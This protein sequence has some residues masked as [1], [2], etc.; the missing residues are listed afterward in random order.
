MKFE[1]QIQNTTKDVIKGFVN[2]CPKDN[3]LANTFR[4]FLRERKK[5]KKK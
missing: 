4:N 5:K 1:L 2:G 3:R